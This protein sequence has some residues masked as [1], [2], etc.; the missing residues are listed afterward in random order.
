[1]EA[2]FYVFSSTIVSH[3]LRERRISQFL[4]LLSAHIEVRALLHFL[5]SPNKTRLTK[6]LVET[7]KRV[8]KGRGWNLTTGE[9]RSLRPKTMKYGESRIWPFLCA[10]VSHVEDRTMNSGFSHRP[11][12]YLRRNQRLPAGC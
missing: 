5:L 2:V 1:M 8:L 6:P 3:T 7:C 12:D 9:R 4:C 11:L 10:L